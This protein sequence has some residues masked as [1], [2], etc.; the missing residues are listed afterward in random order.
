MWSKKAQEFR[1][2]VYSILGYEVDFQPNGRVKV[3]S[4]F[5]RPDFYGGVDTGIIFD[6]EQGMQHRALFESVHC[7]RGSKFKDT[8]SHHLI[9][10][11]KLCGGPNS[12]FAREI[13]N[14]LKFYVEER[15]EIPCFLAALTM[16]G[17]EKTTRA[18]R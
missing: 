5:H 4:I 1:Q 9:G 3:T 12:Q 8:V 6:G 11:M 10:T 18:Q 7:S 17:Y 15:K 16:E 14:Q 2:A 13:K